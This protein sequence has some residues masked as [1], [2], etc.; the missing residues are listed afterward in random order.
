MRSILK[1]KRQPKNKKG[2]I[3]IIIFFAALLLLLVVGFIAAMVWS[4]ID[5]ASDEITPIMEELGVVQGT[6]VSEAAEF[7]FGVAN[8]FVQA[9][10]WLIALGYVMALVFTLVFVFVVG[11]SPHPA[12]IA[13]Y[14]VLMVLLIFGCIVMSNMY[15]DVYTGTDEISTRLQEQTTMSYLILHSPMIMGIIAIIGGVLMFTRRSSAEGG[16]TGGFGV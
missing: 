5:I 1:H 6:N 3:G 16:G 4:V 9:M 12:F 13:F 2:G 15:Q 14:L 11:Y 8:T 10:P 7:S